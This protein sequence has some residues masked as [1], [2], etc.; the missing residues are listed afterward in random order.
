MS[1]N[2]EHRDHMSTVKTIEQSL[3]GILGIAFPGTNWSSEAALATMA[4]L[5]KTDQTDLPNLAREMESLSR[6]LDRLARR[7]DD[8][9]RVVYGHAIMESCS[10]CDH[11]SPEMKTKHWQC[12]VVWARAAAEGD[13]DFRKINCLTRRV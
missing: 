13:Q 11:D 9:P 1:E 5:R 7:Q 12:W 10:G 2:T 6:A 4:E 3:L 8:C